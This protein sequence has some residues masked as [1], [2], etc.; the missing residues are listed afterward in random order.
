M[1]EFGGDVLPG[2]ARFYQFSLLQTDAMLS[3]ETLC[4]VL[5]SGFILPV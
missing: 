2:G 1:I 3:S 5:K 4:S